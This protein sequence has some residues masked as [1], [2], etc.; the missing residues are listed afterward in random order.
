MSAVVVVPAVDAFAVPAA[1]A[2][3]PDDCHLAGVVV[4]DDVV[5]VAV[6]IVVDVKTVVAVKIVVDDELN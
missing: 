2:A 6:K 4:L 1:V 5:V 3:V